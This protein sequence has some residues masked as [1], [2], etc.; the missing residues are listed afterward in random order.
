MNK[1]ILTRIFVYIFTTS[2]W[3]FFFFSHTIFFLH[4]CICSHSLFAGTL[5]NAHE[6]CGFC[7]DSHMIFSLSLLCKKKFYAFSYIVGRLF[8]MKF[9]PLS[10]RGEG[11]GVMETLNRE[12][13]SSIERW[14]R[15]IVNH[16]QINCNNSIY[17]GFHHQH[18][19]PIDCTHRYTDKVS[20][21]WCQ[22]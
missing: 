17:S 5:H 1:N 20:L 7:F 22:Y 21:L 9:F 18:H 11:V 15:L 16:K 19:P 3:L 4:V 2:I 13:E 6:T 10:T 8:R 12:W 14:E